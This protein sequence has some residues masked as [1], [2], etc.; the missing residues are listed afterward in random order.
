MASNNIIIRGLVA[1]SKLITRGFAGVLSAIPV[2][3]C[4]SYDSKV[5][6]QRLYTED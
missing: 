2:K 5:I 3:I 6:C 1:T 4:K